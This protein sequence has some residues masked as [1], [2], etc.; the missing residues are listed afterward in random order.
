[1]GWVGL[2]RDIAFLA[3]FGTG[4]L[5]D[6]SLSCPASAK[7]G[8]GVAC[9]ATVENVG[10]GPIPTGS[11]AYS[12]LGDGTGTFSPCVL[13]GTGECTTTYTPGAAGAVTVFGQYLGDAGH[14]GSGANDAVSVG[15]R[16][17]ATSVNCGAAVAGSATTCTATVSDADTGT[18]STPAGSVAFTAPGGSF[19]P[20]SCNLAGG[21]C[22][23]SFTP[24]AA[25]TSTVT[26]T[27]GSGPR[28]LGSAGNRAVGVA[29]APVTTPAPDC[30]PLRDKLSRLKRKLRKA[31][32]GKKKLRKK[33]AKTKR[34]LAALGC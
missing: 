6:T 4:R 13:N 30:A 5:T 18:A 10:L 25:G 23:V 8:Q 17:S 29:P 33:I 21:A 3:E 9:I 22:S 20:G 2:P 32:S 1:L 19:S 7:V 16:N 31:E 34:E 15:R 26:A 11:V 24:V 12:T 28:H 27:Y 14:M